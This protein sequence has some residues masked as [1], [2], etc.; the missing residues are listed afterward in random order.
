[1]SAA[2]QFGY[3][4]SIARA[5]SGMTQVELS[6]KVSLCSV[7]LSRY[8]NGKANPHLNQLVKLAEACGVQ[9]RDLLYGIE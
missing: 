9:V 4:L 8:E 5:E 3:N 1:M 6:A 2:K 7:T